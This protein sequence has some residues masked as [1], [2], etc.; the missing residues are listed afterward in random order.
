MLKKIIE[1]TFSP[2]ITAVCSIIF[3]WSLTVQQV[4]ECFRNL[5]SVM[6]CTRFFQVHLF[7]LLPTN[8]YLWKC[9]KNA[10][11]KTGF[12]CLENFHDSLVW[13]L[14]FTA[15]AV[16]HEFSFSAIHS[17]PLTSPN[18]VLASYWPINLWKSG[19]NMAAWL[20]ISAWQW[21]TSVSTVPLSLTHIPITANGLLLQH[22][23]C[24]FTEWLEGGF[25]RVTEG[26]E[27]AMGK[28]FWQTVAAE[29]D[30]RYYRL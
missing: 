19:W 5:R 6:I 29:P 26:R 8:R 25:C 27:Y 24:Q 9:R 2:S 7:A 3:S 12:N 17:L 16:W 28:T 1:S 14:F 15:N 11:K 22:C 20:N 4:Q 13:W 10:K 30:G 18:S 21:S 23:L